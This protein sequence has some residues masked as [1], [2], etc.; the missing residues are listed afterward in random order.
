MG[1][2]NM[3]SVWSDAVK[4]ALQTQTTFFSEWN[5]FLLFLTVNRHRLGQQHHLAT[6]QFAL[7]APHPVM[8][9]AEKVD[10]STRKAAFINPQRSKRPIDEQQPATQFYKTCGLNDLSIL[11]R[12]VWILNYH[13]TY[14]HNFQEYVNFKEHCQ[15][16]RHFPIF[17]NNLSKALIARQQQ[18]LD[19]MKAWWKN[20]EP[21]PHC[22]FTSV[23]ATA[24]LWCTNQRLLS[25][26][27]KQSFWERCSQLQATIALV[28][29]RGYR[30]HCRH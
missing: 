8:S 29:D 10:V 30:H 19:R 17:Q 16:L 28:W 13:R 15:P 21:L 20:E 11:F 24:G 25:N 27:E 5:R 3:S 4:A 23:K 26:R 12:K 9:T 1:D 2:S 6:E 14:F 18:A 22:W 7:A